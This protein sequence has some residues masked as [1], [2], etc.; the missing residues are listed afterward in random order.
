[1]LKEY[2]QYLSNAP[3][4][5]IAKQMGF[6]KESVAMSS[7][8]SR[9][10]EQW[11]VHYLQCQQGIL[12]AAI[13][14]TK[15]RTLLIFGAG[16]L[17][18]VPLAILA[19]QFKKIV[20]V[21]L[22]FLK[23]ARKKASKYSNVE[24]V[25]HDVTEC[26]PSVLKGYPD[27]QVPYRWLD[28]EEVDLVVSLNLVTQIPLIPV[29]WLMKK[30]KYSEPEADTIGKQLIFSHL[31]YLQAF[32]ANVCLIADYMDIEF[33]NEGNEIDRFD[34]WWGVEPPKTEKIWDWEVAPLG[35]ISR[36]KSQ[37]NQVGISYF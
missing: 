24:L 33:D 32:S 19:N 13:N 37:V 31:H 6:L 25:E 36:Y 17:N 27:I 18:D 14:C 35:E 12:K 23:P 21:D 28:D 30:Y 34:P 9:C 7:R 11:G 1:M 8:A 3:S 22:V 5:K 20:L 26:L 4:I 29:G 16:S 2:W 10:Q 15:H